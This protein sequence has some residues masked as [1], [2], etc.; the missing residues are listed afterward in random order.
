MA[1]IN[2]GTLLEYSWPRGVLQRANILGQFDRNPAAIAAAT[3]SPA[4]AMDGD[5]MWEDDEENK[6]PKPSRAM[7]V[8]RCTLWAGMKIAN[9]VSGFR[10]DEIANKVSGFRWDEIEKR[11]W[12]NDRAEDACQAREEGRRKMGQR[13]IDGECG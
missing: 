7:L 5:G 2:I 8:R 13:W 9:K 4:V 11:S 1:A 10:W 3:N 6:K 12:S